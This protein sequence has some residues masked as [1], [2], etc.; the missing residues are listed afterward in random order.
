[1]PDVSVIIV[2]H[3]AAPYVR[4]AIATLSAATKR[5]YETIVM[6]NS[7]GPTDDCGADI[8]R[9]VENRGFGA[10]C[11]EGAAL[12]SGALLLFLN[13]DSE[14]QPG[15]LDAACRMLEESEN[16]G[17]V[18]IRTILPGGS[19][20]PGCLRGFPTPERAAAYY[21][22]LERLFPG[23]RLCGGYHM[24]WLDRTQNHEVD[25]V[26]GSFML[27]RRA[28]F[29]ELGGFD[30]DFFMYGED[31]DL[32]C[33]VKEKGLRVLYCA[34]GFMLHHHG[35]C[36]KSP[37]QTAAFYESMILFYEKHYRNLYPK[38]V[39]TAVCTAASLMKR[40]A[41]RKLEKEP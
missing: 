21:L 5:R 31:M 7:D 17:L 10:A 33:R 19:F 3:N 37:R 35:K 15:S 2:N 6:D 18:G 20:E 25:C 34:D 12:A 24:T 29:E 39:Y 9:L 8:Y 16:A 27:L 28:L 11:N 36:G 32:C 14:L 40:R 26:S 23:N 4:G 38:A 13:P 22:G 41:L 30:E 1:M